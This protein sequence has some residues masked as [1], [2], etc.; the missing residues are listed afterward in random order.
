MPWKRRDPTP[1]VRWRDAVTIADLRERAARAAGCRTS[2]SN[3]WRVGAEDEATLRSNR[4]ALR[5]LAAGAARAGRYQCAAYAHPAVRR[6]APQH[7]W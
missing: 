2:R 4:T 7:R 6:P 3:T 5:A 1:A